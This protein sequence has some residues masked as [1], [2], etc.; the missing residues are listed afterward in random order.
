VN[1]RRKMQK[2][3][4]QGLK[5]SGSQSFDV[6]AKAPTLL[7]RRVYLQAVKA[8]LSRG[9]E[10]RIQTLAR[11]KSFRN[12]GFRRIGATLLTKRGKARA[13]KSKVLHTWDCGA[14]RDVT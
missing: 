4:P 14:V 8:M 11:S 10:V 6:G 2:S 9:T 1:E 12:K 7:T 13:K 5:R 3:F